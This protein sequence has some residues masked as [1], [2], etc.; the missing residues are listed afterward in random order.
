MKKLI[1]LVLAASLIASLTASSMAAA[2]VAKKKAVKKPAKKVVKPVK[3]PAPK[4][5]APVTPWVPPAPAP[6][7][8]AP[9][10]A[11]AAAGMGMSIGVNVG[12]AAGL[13]AVT[14]VLDY[15]IASMIPGAKVRVGGD[16]LTGSNGSDSN[17][18]I[19]TL[20]L[21]GLY[22]LDMLKSSAVP[23]DWY[24]G[25]DVTV[26]VK[27]SGGKT[28][29]YGL[30]AYIGGNYMIPDFG[31]INAQVGYSALKYGSTTSGAAKGVL[32]T[33]GYAYSF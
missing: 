23:I 22:A 24:I 29:S 20:K 27:V 26:P 8:P 5:P 18:K 12:V 1:A 9:A 2:K 32:A 31:T 25:G 7:A 21:G 10:P 17:L 30:E 16:Y 13:T 11:P 33:I 4:K 19:V 14:G 6:V 3:K 15:S 28:G